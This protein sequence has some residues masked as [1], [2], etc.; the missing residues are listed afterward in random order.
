MTT[1]SVFGD[2]WCRF[3]NV[4]ACFRYAPIKLYSVYVPPPQLEFN[5]PDQQEWLREEASE[6]DFPVVLGFINFSFHLFSF[7]HAHSLVRQKTSCG[8]FSVHVHLLDLG[9]AYFAYSQPKDL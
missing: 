6:V 7:L 5:N 8:F 2:G 9:A 1:H 4:V 3:G